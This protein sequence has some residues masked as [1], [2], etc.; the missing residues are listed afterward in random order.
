MTAGSWSVLADCYFVKYILRTILPSCRDVSGLQAPAFDTPLPLSKRFGLRLHLLV[1][2]WCRRYGRQI[3]FLRG[4][5]QAR[6]EKL[7]E[8]E[9]QSLPNDA[10]ERLKKSLRD[11]SE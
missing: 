6:P 4:A 2:S 3:T 8:S 1:C 9:P 10:R 11:S 5:M 7:A